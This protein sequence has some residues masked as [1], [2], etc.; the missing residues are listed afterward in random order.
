MSCCLIIAG[1]GS[2][3]GCSPVAPRARI[4]R[5]AW[6]GLVRVMRPRT[7][8]PV[9]GTRGPEGRVMVTVGAGADFC[10]EGVE[11]RVPAREE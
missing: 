7:I 4:E 10:F 8:V 3:Q 9:S 2:R 5:F 6:R 11:V 1:K